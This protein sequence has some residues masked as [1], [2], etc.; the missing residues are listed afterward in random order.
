MIARTGM[1]LPTLNVIRLAL[2]TVVLTG[3]AAADT[4]DLVE[5]WRFKPDPGDAGLSQ[6]WYAVDHPDADWAVARAGE[7]WEDQGF[8]EVD[9]AA[10][11]RR[12]FEAPAV[13][14]GEA[15]WF[16]AG[17]LNDGG[18]LYCNG[19]RVTE[20]GDDSN[21]M[22]GKPVLAELS[23]FL[24]Y[25]QS[26]V[27]ALR[28]FDWGASGGLWQLPCVLTTDAGRLPVESIVACYPDAATGRLEVEL[29]LSPFGNDRAEARV[30][31]ELQRGDG[32]PV[33]TREAAAYRHAPTVDVS[34]PWPPQGNGNAPHRL[35]VSVQGLGRDGRAEF[36]A[37]R[38]IR[39]PE[40]PAWPQVADGALDIRNNFVTGL[41]DVAPVPSEAKS[42]AFTNPRDGWV[43]FAVSNPAD[44][45]PAAFLDDEDGPLV[46]RP[47]PKSG[48]LEA[49]RCL[50]EGAH[51]LRLTHAAGAGLAIRAVPE[52]AFCYYPSSRHIE[53][54]GPYD[55]DYMTRH[56][57]SDVNT[58]ITRHTVPPDQFDHWIAEGRQ[59]IANAG[60]PGLGAAEAPSADVVYDVWAGNAGVTQPGFAG[61]IVD[62]FLWAGAQHYAAWGEGVRR[63]HANPEF[64]GR[65]FYAWCGDLF[66]QTPSRAF[67]RLLMDLG[68]RFSWERYLPEEP[69][70]EKAR[71]RLARDVRHRFEQWKEALPGIERHMVVCLGYLS[72]PPETLNLN[73]SVDYHVYLDMQFHHLA[74]DP[75]YWGLYG[76][77][78]YMA[79][80]ADEESLLY[81]QKLFRHYCIDGNRTR[82]NDDPYVLPHLRNPDFA[83]G[84]DGWDAEPAG[85][86]GI[87]VEELVGFSWL[88]GRYPRTKEGD[89]FCRMKRSAAAPNR[90]SQTL[91]ALEPGRLYSV[92]LISADPRRLDEKQ[93]VTVCLGVSGGEPM[94]EYGF[95][96][97]YPS[98]YSHE[99]E[100]HNRDHPAY[101]SFHRVVFRATGASAVLTISDWASPSEPGA[102]IGQETAFNFVEVQPFHQP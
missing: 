52:I 41:L 82:L 28:V 58:L 33:H 87:D 29:D 85:D 66:P 10:W 68:Y 95:Q 39:M 3:L 96:F 99:V 73:P 67:S 72:A 5:D 13:W 71:R 50:A 8:A 74:T 22:A 98:C 43:F 48:A 54:Y 9:G 84:L 51:R 62:E 30:L 83:E 92:K 20:Y 90:V 38:E 7:R 69:T 61:M 89:R 97:V 24:R 31:V 40:A 88:Q 42:Y 25:G 46:W 47:H 44:G 64:A 19:Q 57:L 12:R 93:P 45:A 59:W 70:P 35:S 11:Y 37:A 65:T 49:M 80:Y 15:V 91:E 23:G 56:V 79:A 78:E 101:L 102:P 55:W 77:M 18:T 16:A 21:S 17:A 53:P 6:A 4:V 32:A 60:L 1:L 75:A 94:E 81:A 26:N 14:E 76:V 2:G 86:G 34:L 36:A 63:L 100:P 27:L